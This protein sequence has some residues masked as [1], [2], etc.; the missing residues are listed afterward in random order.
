MNCVL[1]DALV[2]AV[3]AA[4]WPMAAHAQLTLGRQVTV[5]QT[6]ATSAYL[7]G[8]VGLDEQAAMRRF[9]KGFP[10]RMVFSENKNR[11]FLADIP[12]VISDSSGNS[13][14]E[15]PSAGPM[16][17]VFLPR[18][19]Y[20]VSAR[21]MGVTQTQEVTLA[22]HDGKDLHFHWEGTPRSSIWTV[23]RE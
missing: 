13:I 15:L 8:G 19:R 7:N 9:A 22:G 23:A 3:L 20:K 2:G 4:C 1:R 10:L 21:F 5:I 11:E 18:G 17:Y 6:V 14:L 16:L 12:L